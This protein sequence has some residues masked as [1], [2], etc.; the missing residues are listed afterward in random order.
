VNN[1]PEIQKIFD[2]WYSGLPDVE[3]RIA[4]RK[5]I[6]LRQMFNNMGNMSSRV[7]LTYLL[8]YRDKP[9]IRIRK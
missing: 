5:L 8:L 6:Q 4:D 9:E 3:K 2:D 7:C 1:D